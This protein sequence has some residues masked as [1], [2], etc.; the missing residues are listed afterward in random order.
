MQTVQIHREAISTAAL[1]IHHTRWTKPCEPI[2]CSGFA[3]VWIKR[4]QINIQYKC[5]RGAVFSV[6]IV[7][8]VWLRYLRANI[9]GQW[10]HPDFSVNLLFDF[11]SR[12]VDFGC[13]EV[14]NRRIKTFRHRFC[15]APYTATATDHNTR[16]NDYQRPH[17][18]DHWT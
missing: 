6:E 7:I 18:S 11:V 17:G 10:N 9:F 15:R 2:Y 12:V 14:C 16:T 3:F 8:R 4:D 1:C 13:S 5:R